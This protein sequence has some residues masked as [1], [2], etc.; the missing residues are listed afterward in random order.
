[1]SWDIF[2]Q[3]FPANAKTVAEIPSDFKPASIGNRTIIIEKIKDIVPSADFS[4][5]AYGVIDGIGWSIEVSIP[6]EECKGF[7]FHVRGGDTAVGV[8][9]AI[10]QCLRLRALD[11]QTG[12]FFEAGPPALDSFYAWRDYRDRVVD[13]LE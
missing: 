3:D 1:M 13:K 5:P 6:E 12:K 2:V 7:A 10:L 9:A 11:A 4:N 8:V